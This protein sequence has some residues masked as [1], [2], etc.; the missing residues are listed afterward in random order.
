VLAPVRMVFHSRF[1]LAALFGWKLEWRSPARSDESTPW[2]TAFAKHGT[3]A[4]AGLVWLAALAM[5]D[6]NAA[7]WTLPVAAALM[8]AVPVSVLSSRPGLGRKA[9]SL[10]V[11]LVPEELVVPR[12]LRR[13]RALA[14]QAQDEAR[15][16]DWVAAIVDPRLHAVV[17]ASAP[18]RRGDS[19]QRRNE[20]VQHVARALLDGPSSLDAGARRRLLRDRLALV[21]LHRLAWSHSRAHAE[22]RHA[23]VAWQRTRAERGL[24]SLAPVRATPDERMLAAA[25]EH[26]AEVQRELA[27]VS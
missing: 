9:R 24:S 5:L 27:L 4:F 2:R 11:F 21:H 26:R 23:R 19:Q 7:L 8:L 1:V 22:W 14:A 3:H 25:R 13:T 18:L 10:G 20:R 12:E 15:R 16:H 6:V 17:A